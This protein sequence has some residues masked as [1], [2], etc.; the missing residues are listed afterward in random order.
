MPTDTEVGNFVINSTGAVTVCGGEEEPGRSA[1]LAL[2]VHAWQ[3]D[4]GGS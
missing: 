2:D 3:H 1:I 4:L